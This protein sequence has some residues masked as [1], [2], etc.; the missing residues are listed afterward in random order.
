ML[1]DSFVRHLD[2][3]GAYT[4]I[5]HDLH[6][7]DEGRMQAGSTVRLGEAA[8]VE[9]AAGSSLRMTYDRSRRTPSI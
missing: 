8:K 4:V 6:V 5:D 1:N 2:N 9:G 3:N 7:H